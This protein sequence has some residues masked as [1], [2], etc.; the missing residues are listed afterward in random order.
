MNEWLDAFQEP[1]EPS[2]PLKPV[3]RSLPNEGSQK[4]FLGEGQTPSSSS[5]L[6][7]ALLAVPH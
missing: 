6:V 4:H 7:F 2:S 1:M 5:E 3:L